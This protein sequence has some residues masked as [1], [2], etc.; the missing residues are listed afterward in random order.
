[1]AEPDGRPTLKKNH[2]QKTAMTTNPNIH[3]VRHGDG[4]AV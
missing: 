2:F 4:W 3:V 1:M